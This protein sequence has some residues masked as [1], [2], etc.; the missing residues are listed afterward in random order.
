MERPQNVPA[1]AI[2]NNDDNQWELGVKNSEGRKIGEWKYWWGTTGHLCCQ[3]FSEEAIDVLSYTRFHPDG[4]YSQKGTLINGVPDGL[5][6][7]QKSEHETTEL[8]LTEPQ[9]ANV[10]RV[11]CQ[12]DNGVGIWWQYYDKDNAPVDLSGS[13]VTTEEQL[14]GNFSGH[15]LTH[16][17]VQLL[18]FEQQYGREVFAEGFSFMTDCEYAITSWSENKAFLQHMMP[19]ASANGSGSTYALWD[20]GKGKTLTGMPVVVFGDE[21]GVHIVARNI[22]ALMQLLTYDTE[23]S[24]GHDEV[25]FYKDEEEH[26]ESEFAQSYK[27]WLKENFELDVVTEPAAI[28]KA[29]QEEYKASFDT[30]FKQYY[31]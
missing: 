31:E 7:Y 19:F 9:Y 14:A 21:G 2:F 29:A 26:T 20:E 10:F 15:Q 12:V 18:S 11:I 8:I 6:Y 5:V 3:A 24:V 13:L 30:W 17:F 27:D 1:E 22:L 25:Y 28:I 4:T 23:I 16:E